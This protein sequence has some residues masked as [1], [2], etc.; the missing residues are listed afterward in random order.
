MKILWRNGPLAV[1]EVRAALAEERDVE[2]AHT[3]VVTTLNTMTEKSLVSRQ[4]QGKAY[5]FRAKVTEEEVSRAML[6]DLLDRV[7]DG[8][9]ES[10]VLHLLESEKIDDEEHQALRRLINR[11]RRE[12]QP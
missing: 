4:Q 6:G 8:S 10:L 12:Q 9:A 2:L 7:F 1:R 5:R 11:K 3:T